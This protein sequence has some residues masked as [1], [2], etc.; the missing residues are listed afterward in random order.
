[1]TELS[2][3]QGLPPK[4]AFI[5]ATGILFGIKLDWGFPATGALD[6]AYTEIQVSPDGTS[7]IAQLGLFAYPT[8][9]HTIQGL[10]P[11][12]TQF[13][14]GR[15][16]D[17]IGNIG[18]W[19]DWTHA[20]TSADATDVLELLNDQI[21]ETQLS[22][23]LKTKIDQIETIDVQ[24]PE[25]KQDIKNTKDQISQEVKD[26]KDS[27]QQA[28]DQ[29]NNNL[30][31]ERDARIKDIDSTNQLIAQEVQDRINADFSEQKA[32][33]AAILA[34]AKLRD[35]AITSEKEERIEGD[36]HLSQRIEAVSASSSDNAAAIQREEKARTDA[37][38]ALG[39]RIDTVV[40]QA[41]D[42]A[43]AI[44]QEAKARVDG[45]SANASLIE[46][47]RA[48]SI[49]ND[50]QTRALVT[51]ESRAR[52]DADK[53]LAERV[54][55]VEVV[56]KPA[57]IGSESDLIGNDAGY[58][59]VWSIL[60]A[61]QEG[62]L[63]QAKRTD[64]VIVSVN[65]NAA[66]INSEQI[67]RI[68][69]DKVI[70]K[71]LTDYAASNDQALANV[72]QSA[73]SAVSKSESN[74]K[75]LTELD[76]R[77]NTVDENANEAKQNAASALSKAETAVSEAGSAASIAQQAHA[78]AT[79]ATTT[80]NSAADNANEAKQT[81]AMALLQANAAASQ[82]GANAEQIQSIRVELKDK[83]STGA[84]DQV[85][86]DIKN[87][88]DK[89]N[90][91]TTKID[92]VYAQLNP[93]LIGSESDLIGNDGGYAGVWSE[94]SA[95]IEGDLAVSKRVDSTTAELGDLQAYT[96]QEVQA[97][98]DGD[99]VTVQ[100]VDNY[101]ASNDSALAAVR[102]TAKLGVDQSSANIEAIKNINIEL[103][104]KATTGDIVQVKSDIKDVD[105]KIIAQTTRIDG[106]Y[107]QLNPPLIGSES[108]LI[109]NDGGYAGVW[110]E[111]SARIE[112][113]LAQSKRTDQVS[114]QMNESNALFQQQINA[115]ASAISSTIK[116]T[117]T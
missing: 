59:G 5:Q 103:K 13:Y 57:L 32:R 88:D 94:Q 38:S 104:D 30:T 51:D 83:A 96:R 60:S 92:G 101:I 87:V 102:D 41:G 58:A 16:I 98:I 78:E 61:V 15:L 54:T 97:R 90:A 99:K 7:N 114:A 26:R 19:S 24:I 106:V 55:G 105:N 18:P 62:D 84:V 12:L 117:E 91:Q 95:R 35:T 21:S 34:E 6:T 43:A 113:D 31:L 100:K 1:L 115:N 28:V 77:V 70:A 66:S 67:A 86:S 107:A 47:V 56:T 8:T 2:G 81:S 45:D 27:V 69:G 14:R 17:R 40:A 116:V 23:D 85:K 44:Q 39:Q 82:S 36:E 49:E 20:T 48:E 64:Q 93:P 112:G 63:L 74:A 52:I 110:S 79:T 75:A 37:D 80:A 109:G 65:Q 53:A 4:L 111:Q 72:R 33:E 9:T 71:A 50:A 89:V 11:N 10:Q 3:K 42:N 73:E 76:S 22:Q 25:I 46:T 108:D 29:A 68:E